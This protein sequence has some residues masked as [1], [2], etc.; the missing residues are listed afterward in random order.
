[1]SNDQCPMNDQ[2]PMT[3]GQLAKGCSLRLGH[4]ALGIGHSLDI[5]HWSLVILL[6]FLPGGSFAARAFAAE[7]PAIHLLASVQ[8]TGEGIFLA[9]I[10]ATNLAVALPQIRL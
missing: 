2:F 10:A 1:M 8:V 9:Q 7:A 6:L 3:N 5:G 4:W